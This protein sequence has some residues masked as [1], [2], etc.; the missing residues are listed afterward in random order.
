MATRQ[1][2]EQRMQLGFFIHAAVYVAV[3]GG[4]VA[5]NFT[6]NPDKL[7]SLWV[8]GGWGLGV[9]FHAL[10]VFVNTRVHERAVQRTMSRLDRRSQSHGR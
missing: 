10:G 4:L 5:M 7:W 6:R 3:V 2:A 9:G 1:Q 8:A